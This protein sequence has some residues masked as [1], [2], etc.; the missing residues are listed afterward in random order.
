[1]FACEI[2]ALGNFVTFKSKVTFEH[3]GQVKSASQILSA[4][5]S[6]AIALDY[7]DLLSWMIAVVEPKPSAPCRWLSALDGSLTPVT[8]C[9]RWFSCMGPAWC[10]MYRLTLLHTQVTTDQSFVVETNWHPNNCVSHEGF[11][12]L[13]SALDKW[14]IMPV[15]TKQNSRVLQ[16]LFSIVNNADWSVHQKGGWES[17]FVTSWK[18]CTFLW[19]KDRRF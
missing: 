18:T 1:M 10:Q 11:S 9:D 15:K 19:V 17:R 12:P 2:M 4:G 16:V 13:S 3:R 7:Q 14:F 6:K 5:V 8:S